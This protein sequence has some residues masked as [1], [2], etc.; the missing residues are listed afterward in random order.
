MNQTVM[1]VSMGMTNMATQAPMIGIIFGIS[2]IGIVLISL[3]AYLDFKFR[4][5][6]FTFFNQW[7][8]FAKI[9]IGATAVGVFAI[10]GINIIYFGLT[11]EKI[12]TEVLAPILTIIFGGVGFLAIMGLFGAVVSSTFSKKKKCV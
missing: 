8:S 5:W 12:Q 1:N 2:I 6:L 9:G 10:I 7:Y 3:F 11:D 4:T